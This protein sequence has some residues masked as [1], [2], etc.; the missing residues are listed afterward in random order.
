MITNIT[1]ARKFIAALKSG[2]YDQVQGNLVSYPG[3]E[4]HPE[5]KG[6]CYCAEG[7]FALVALGG[8][9]DGHRAVFELNG[10]TYREGGYLS[11]DPLVSVFG[12]WVPIR[13]WNDG[14]EMSFSDIAER[15]EEMYPE[16][17]A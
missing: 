14:H 4:H 1:A 8:S 16:L 2:D 3:E 15:L 6:V 17:K 9:F 13:P 10:E 7:L 12:E 5:G 11:E